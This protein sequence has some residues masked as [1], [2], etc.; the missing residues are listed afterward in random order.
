MVVRRARRQSITVLG[1]IAQRTAEAR[2]STW[3]ARAAATRASSGSTIEELL[4][5]YRVPDDFLRVAATLHRRR[6][7]PEGVRQAPWPA[8]AVATAAV[9]EVALALAERMEAEVVGSVGVIVPAALHD[10]V[11]AAFGDRAATRSRRRCRAGVN[12]VGLAAIKGL[13]FDAAVVR[14]ARGDPARAPRRR[15]RRALHGAHALDPRARRRPRRAAAGGSGRGARPARRARA[16]RAGPRHAHRLADAERAPPLA[17]LVQ[18][19]TCALD[20]GISDRAVAAT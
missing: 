12:L 19:R 9:G 14:R 4:V 20:L 15:P 7:V 5:S 18:Q 6:A 13:E 17:Q 2:L 10:A 3:D 11:A 8:V 16:P 1:D